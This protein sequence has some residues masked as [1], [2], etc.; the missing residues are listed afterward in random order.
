MISLFHPLSLFLIGFSLV[1][2]FRMSMADYEQTAI[3]KIAGYAVAQGLIFGAVLP[4][5]YLLITKIE[6]KLRKKN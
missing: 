1:T 4:L 6:E 2:I 5:G 3:E